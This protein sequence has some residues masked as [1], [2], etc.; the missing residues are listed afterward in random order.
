[1][2]VFLRAADVTEVCFRVPSLINTSTFSTRRLKYDA[3]SAV[4]Y[5]V[6]SEAGYYLNSV[7]I[8]SHMVMK[9]A[10][11]LCVVVSTVVS[12]TLLK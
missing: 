2:Y 5:L 6:H 9:M 7:R 8:R 3:Q 4:Q 10:Y 11:L 1:M 12:Q